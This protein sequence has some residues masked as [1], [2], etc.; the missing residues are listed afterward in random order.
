MAKKMR[1]R[2]RVCYNK[3]E[4]KQAIEDLQ[5]RGYVLK[6]QDRRS[7]VLVKQREKKLHGVI[8]ILTIWW[9]LGLINL[10]YAMLPKKKD[11]EVTLILQK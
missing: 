1:K 6:S 5:D 3:K 10:L 11:D 4:F 9:S 8:A 2:T 7:A